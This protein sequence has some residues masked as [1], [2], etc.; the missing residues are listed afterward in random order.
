MI[1][2]FRVAEVLLALFLSTGA[3]LSHAALTGSDPAEG[4]VLEAAPVAVTLRF[5]EPVRP[6]VARLTASD[7]ETR[8]L[9]APDAAGGGLTYDLPAGLQRGSH[10]LSWRVTSSDGHPVAGALLFSVGAPS[11]EM[12]EVAGAPPA[13][14]IGLWLSRAML[15]AALLFSVGGGIL[16]GETNRFPRLAAL[17]GLLVLPAYAGFRGLDLLALSPDALLTT[18]PWR[19]AVAGVPGLALAATAVAL[20]VALWPGRLAAILSLGLAGLAAAISGHA[21]TAPPQWLMRPA[22]AVH[23]IS[24]AV[25]IG[26]LAPLLVDL[27]RGG[28]GALARFSRRVPWVLALLLGSGVAIALV[29]LGNLAALWDTDYGRV[30]MFKLALVGLLLAL[31]GVNRLWLTPRA[32]RGE[33]RPLRRAVRVE[34]LMVLPILGAVALWQF[35]PPPRSLPPGP[36]IAVQQIQKG[37]VAA[38]IEVSP[39]RAGM[40]AL[41][42]TGLAVDGAPVDARPVEIELSKPAYGL[43]P[44]RHQ[45]T[46]QDGSVDAGRFL[47]PLDGF[48][49]LRLKV[50]VSDFRAEELTDLIEIA[51]AR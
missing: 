17:A 6:L 40:V 5:S 46:A 48:W 3:A 33:A 29:Q 7:G 44:F 10:L 1:R 30:L 14:R 22:V 45:A 25:W 50:L 49:V 16:A 32:E 8:L 34:I 47:L 42:L 11:G 2:A 24:A 21:A 26:A 27:A 28:Q 37:A 41:R 51:P 15:L 12:V 4:M 18:A 43:G 20:V 36:R 19:E 31:A 38:R 9:P 23:V 39:P 35:T 13:T